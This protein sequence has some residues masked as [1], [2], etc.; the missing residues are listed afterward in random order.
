MKYITLKLKLLFLG[1]TMIS[2][3]NII[4]INGPS[5]SGKTSIAKELQSQ[6]TD[7]YLHVG[8]DWFLSTMPKKLWNHP[9]GFLLK[10]TKE[11]GKDLTQ[12]IIGKE[13]QKLVNSIGPV[14]KSLLDSGNN[15][16]IDEVIL[17]QECLNKYLDVLKNHTT[18][19]VGTTAPIEVLRKREKQRGDRAIGMAEEQD[20]LTH[21]FLKYDLFIDT[22]NSKPAD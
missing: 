9:D 15:L 22:N 1:T 12:I 16:I 10:Q 3:N 11:D 2:A 8:I 17:S 13:G 6:L 20:K 21:K 5:S 19:F 14:I 18:L 4:F 7:T